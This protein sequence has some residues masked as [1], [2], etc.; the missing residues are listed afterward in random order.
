M[1]IAARRRLAI[2]LGAGGAPVCRLDAQ[3]VTPVADT[4]G[5]DAPARQALAERLAQQVLA[6]AW[7]ALATDQPHAAA[8]NETA[9]ADAPALVEPPPPPFTSNAEVPEA[10]PPAGEDMAALL[11][12]VVGGGAVS[13]LA[14]SREGVVL[15][16]HRD[17]RITRPDAAASAFGSH[18]GHRAA[19]TALCP[20]TPGRF[21]SAAADGSVMLW[22]GAGPGGREIGRHPAAVQ[23]LA[24]LGEAV[25][26]GDA[27][28]LLQVWPSD[29]VHGS[30]RHWQL[31]QGIVAIAVGVEHLHVL[32]DGGDLWR[33]A[34]HEPDEPAPMGINT[35]AVCCLACSGDTLYLGGHDPQDRGFVHRR[36]LTRG[37]LDDRDLTGLPAGTVRHVQVLD[38]ERVVF[39]CDS[40]DIFLWSPS[41]GA[42]HFENLACPPS[43]VRAMSAIDRTELLVLDDEGSV[44][45]WP[46][47]SL[48]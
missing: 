18:D 48:R 17:G 11:G 6:D 43:P 30:G 40:G 14:T 12:A 1:V 44:R 45:R 19:V 39:A 29:G 47:P 4:A 36:K 32:G 38:D 22:D 13:A 5:L 27:Q 2:Q 9:T 35:G 21:A 20:L 46:L 23:A 8:A 41:V 25:V 37:G 3:M 7:V 31:D 34:L 42:G 26:A 15:L 10:T 24:P 16:G 28:G 33:I